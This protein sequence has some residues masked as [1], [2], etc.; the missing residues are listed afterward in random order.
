M[1]SNE[2]CPVTV[3]TGFLGAGKTTLLNAL[4]RSD[5]GL[6]FAV[7]V[8]EFGALGIDGAL[9]ESSEDDIIQLSNGCLCC[10]VRGDLIEACARIAARR[11][12][13]D[14]LVIETSGLADPASIAQSFLLSDGPSLHFQ[15]DGI[16][17]LADAKHVERQMSEDEIASQQLALADRIVITKTDLISSQD[18]G[19]ISDRL[20]AINASA[21]IVS[22]SEGR[23]AVEHI[24]GLQA[25][26]LGGL[27]ARLRFVAPPAHDGTIQSLSFAF[28]LPLD[29]SRFSRFV[30]DY[31]I[32]RGP[33][34]LRIKGIIWLDG[35]DRRF[36]FHG[37]QTIVDGDVIGPWPEGPR[38][39]EIVFIGRGLDRDLIAAGLDYCVVKDTENILKATVKSGK[40]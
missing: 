2:K 6:R 26:L 22:S 31:L 18:L 11:D 15:L 23:P 34:L 5:T 13:F 35:E 4:I 36:A 17:T 19:R 39:S 20:R 37:V 8:N 16:V 3:L 28:D 38:R 1:A 9:I 10:T 7:I 29:F 14:W 25:Y 24:T 12:E 32:E 33:D 30:Q 40:R 27:P 21:D